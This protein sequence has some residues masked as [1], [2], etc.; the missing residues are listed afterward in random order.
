MNI[1]NNTIKSFHL[2]KGDQDIIY[3]V[4][5]PVHCKDI[6]TYLTRPVTK[7]PLLLDDEELDN[8]PALGEMQSRGR[9]FQG[10]ERER[11]RER[12]RYIYISYIY[13][14]IIL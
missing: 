13:I 8:R 9:K 3:G 5:A 7:A 14:Y 1:A 10:K 12:E 11:E 6:R 4:C 2:E